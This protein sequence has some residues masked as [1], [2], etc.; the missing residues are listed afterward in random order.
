MRERFEGKDDGK[1]RRQEVFAQQEIVQHND[2]IARKLNDLAQVDELQKGQQLYIQGEPGKNSLFFILSGS[3]DLSVQEKHISI[4][5]PGQAVGEFPI[6][7]PS[8]PYTVN[9]VARE[10]SV[11]ARVSEEQFLSIATEYPEIWKNMARMLVNRLRD[12]NELHEKDQ[13]TAP[14]E[15]RPGDLTIVQL[16]SGL[17]G[18]E[19]WAIIVAIIG[20]ISAIGTVAYKIGSGAW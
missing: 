6:L 8:L 16:I 14:K 20:A 9:V 5:K 18:A 2:T 1:R 13:Q 17:T 15:L 4:L 11:V 12:A 3:F 19:L 10:Q 7:E